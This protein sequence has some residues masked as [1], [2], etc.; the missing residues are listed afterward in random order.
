MSL[1]PREGTGSEVDQGGGWGS[2]SPSGEQERRLRQVSRGSGV[3]GES[4]QEESEVTGKR[5]G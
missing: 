5:G 2:L 1:S 3:L 4:P